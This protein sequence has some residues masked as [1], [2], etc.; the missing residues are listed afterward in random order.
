[1]TVTPEITR[2]PWPGIEAPDYAKYHDEEWGVPLTGDVALFEKLTLE[3]FQSGLS[4]LTILRKRDN[5]R[6]AFC[7]FDIARVAAFGGRDV[8]RLMSDAGIVRNRRKIDAAINNARAA[9]SLTEN[10]GTSL[11]DFL[12]S[13]ALKTPQ[14][15]TSVSFADVPSQTPTSREMAKALKAHGFAHLGPTTLYAMMQSTGM[16]NDH[17][18]ACH[19]HAPCQ[20]LQVQARKRRAAK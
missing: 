17:L 1:M 16:V 13:F 14:S 9:L 15:S 5:F 8:A 2:C 6:R 11:T 18:S 12:W 3:S 10:T 4:W 19:R 20:K 7:D